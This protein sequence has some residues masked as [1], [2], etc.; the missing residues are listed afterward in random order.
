MKNNK[1]N[2]FVRNPFLYLLIIVAAVTGFQY[3]FAGNSIGQSQQINYTELVKEIK[4][5]N[6]KEISYQPNGS[7]IEISGTYN[8]AKPV[9]MIQGFS[10]SL[11]AQARSLASLV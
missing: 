11:Q 10:F 6:V 3:F 7:V 2:G 9:R 1:N 4:S 8:K 5:D